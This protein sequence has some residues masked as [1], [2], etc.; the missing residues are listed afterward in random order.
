MD[1]VILR[2]VFIVLFFIVIGVFLYMLYDFGTFQE[3]M[4]KENDAEEK[5]IKLVQKNYEYYNDL[6][7]TLSKAVNENTQL[8][9][10][11]QVSDANTRKRIQDIEKSRTGTMKAFDDNVVQYGEYIELLNKNNKELNKTIL[12]S[13]VCATAKKI[14]KQL[15]E[16]QII[17]DLM[18]QQTNEIWD[19]IGNIQYTNNVIDSRVKIVEY[20]INNTRQSCN[21]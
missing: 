16:M 1:N 19:I 21:I 10:S 5:L 11:L 2:T 12:F 13:N 7:N 9:K 15:G 17:L 6:N 14:K 4:K 18:Q 8:T 20:K 3:D